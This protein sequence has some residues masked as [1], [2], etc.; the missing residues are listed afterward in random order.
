VALAHIT[1]P[2]ETPNI[3]ESKSFKLYLNSFNNTR[4]ADPPSEVQERIRT[5][6]SEA[7]WRGAPAP[8]SVGVKPPAP[9][10]STA[11]RCT[12]WTGCPWTGWMSSAPTTSPCPSC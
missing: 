11:S 3:V 2:C 5:D 12:R 9:T 8:S 1:V 6:V 10:C 4:F 7:G